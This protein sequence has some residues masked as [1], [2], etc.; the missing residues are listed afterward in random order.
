MLDSH[1]ILL[2]SDIG[3]GNT[4]FIFAYLPKALFDCILFYI[5]Q[6]SIVI[7]IIKRERFLQWYL[8]YYLLRG[9]WVVL[10]SKYQNV[11]NNT[12]R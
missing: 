12:N 10:E 6:L 3:I 7:I 2:N 5:S 8:I 4:S 9:V 11:L 1:S